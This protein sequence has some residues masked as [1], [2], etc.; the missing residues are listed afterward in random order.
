[1]IHDRDSKFCPAF[2]GI[3]K[4]AGV[5]PVKLPPRSPNLNPVAERWVKSVKV[6]ALSRLI[7]FSEEALRRALREYLAHYHEERNHQ[8]FENQLLF[9]DGSFPQVDG[10][11]CSKERLGGLL[12]FY[13]RK[14][15]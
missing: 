2:Q 15:A 3:I 12:R 11:I 13:H 8:S 5:E 6:D 4:D 14:V 7:F 9:P 10:E 1:M